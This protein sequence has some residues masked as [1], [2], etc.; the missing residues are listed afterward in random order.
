MC[1]MT[2]MCHHSLCAMTHKRLTF[3]FVRVTWVIY[4]CAMTHKCVPWLICAMSHY[5]PWLTNDS[6]STYVCAMTHQFE[7]R[8][9]FSWLTDA[10]SCLKKKTLVR[11]RWLFA[12][13]CHD[14]VER[15]TWLIHK[16][17]MTRMYICK[18][19]YNSCVTHD[20]ITCVTWL[21]HK[22]DMT[23]SQVL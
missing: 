14:L 10:H 12:Y 5:V 6:R 11:V 2:H 4:M 7:W 18:W 17:D 1:A 3:D 16:R 20:T 9:P 15:V 13:V 19:N 23:Q 22:C 21:I 8:D